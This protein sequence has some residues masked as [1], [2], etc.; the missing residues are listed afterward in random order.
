M[1]AGTVLV[2]E[3]HGVSHRVTVLDGGFD[4]GGGRFRSLSE[5]ARKITGVRWSGPLFFGLKSSALALAGLAADEGFTGLTLG[6]QRVEL[7][8]EALLR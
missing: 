6:M 2:R 7:L 3:W 8:L 4:L 1:K 5:I